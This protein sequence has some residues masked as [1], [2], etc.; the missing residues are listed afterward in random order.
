MEQGSIV[1]PSARI[2]VLC[3][4][5][6]AALSAATVHGASIGGQLFE[7]RDRDGAFDA[8]EPALANFRVQLVGLE[9]TVFQQ[10]RSAAD[11]TFEFNGLADGQYLLSVRPRGPFRASLPDPGADPPPIPDFP[12]GRPRYGASP[13]LAQ[14]LSGAA[15]FLHVGLGDS[16]GFGFNACG[17]LLGEDGYFEPTSARLGGTT[18]PTLFGDKQSI[19]GHE[20][21]DLLDPGTSGDFPFTDNDVFYAVDEGS[22]LVS[23]SIGGNDFLGAE[24]G[25]DPAVAAALVT[26]RR[27]LQEILSS[28]AS[29]LPG[30]VLEINT[31]YDNEEGDDAFH[32]VWVPIWDQ[33]V[34]ELAWAQER[35][36][37]LAEI[38][39][40]YAHDEGGVLLGEPGLI[41]ND[42]FGLDGIHPTGSGYDVHEEKLWQSLGGVTLAGSDRLDVELGF[43]RVRRQLRPRQFEE[44]A[45]DT[46]DP[47]LALETDDQGAL[48][49]S[50]NAEFRVKTFLTITPGLDLSQALLK[51]RYRTTGAPIDDYYRIE[52]SLD[53]TFSPPGST[54]SDWNTILPVVGSS[55][56]DGVDV[57]AFPDQPDF[58][59]VAA[60]LYAGSPT[61]NDGTLEWIDLQTLSVRVVTTAVGAADPFDVELDSAWV[62]IFVQPGGSV[63][64]EPRSLPTRAAPRPLEELLAAAGAGA[65]GARRD[66]ARELVAHGEAVP[67]AI[68]LSLA[69]DP[70]AATRR[71]ALRALAGRADV[72][73]AP[74]L[75][76][77]LGDRDAGVRI[78]AAAALLERGDPAGVP[79][80]IEALGAIPPSRRAR[81]ALAGRA[82]AVPGLLAALGD[83]D[84]A[85]RAGA[86]ELLAGLAD[87]D[88]S[89]EIVPALRP[90]L[91]DPAA[92]VRGAAAHALG[93]H[94]D[95]ASADA[96]AE[97]ARHPATVIAA[98]EALA[99]LDS[100]AAWEALFE[101]AA[102]AGAR[103]TARRL[104]ARGL[105]DAGGDATV[106]LGWLLS[107]DD[108]RIRRLAH[109]GLER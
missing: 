35:P 51:V 103:P 81:E 6:L 79:T 44:V 93:A 49:P 92:A 90:L 106:W 28:L 89:A 12:F 47:E 37:Q 100:P 56:N 41:C 31:V 42:L 11:G 45:G 23:I 14:R 109:S 75:Y 22:D 58:R 69:D 62:E 16:I 68:L 29:E 102:D 91:R 86:A 98:A 8:G 26:A 74:L 3:A 55:G 66:L 83:A 77:A 36:V 101:I 67:A 105:A 60:P 54:P 61:S 4:L 15:S 70:E 76:R 19:P 48:I 73:A 13:D 97:L 94:G 20:T 52:A 1:R 107:S 71:I 63:A 96:I 27:N 25:G 59:V 5:L 34:R 39:P 17:S 95:A 46:I 9:G 43:A 24:D 7:D 87:R 53:G 84:P 64:P 82:E 72:A 57:L 65:P 2:V 18:A 108:E 50:D 33:V 85:L 21:S 30:A 104:A 32:N 80:L 99:G 88:G 38:Y 10:T 78:E 40:E